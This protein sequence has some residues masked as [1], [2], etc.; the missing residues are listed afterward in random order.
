M[1]VFPHGKGDLGQSSLD[2]VS[3]ARHSR[4]IYLNPALFLIDW[5]QRGENEQATPID[6]KRDRE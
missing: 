5:I 1:E 2:G 3:R 4:K 6:G